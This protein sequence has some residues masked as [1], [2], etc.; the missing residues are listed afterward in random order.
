MN[1]SLILKIHIKNVT[2]VSVKGENFVRENRV[3]IWIRTEKIRK[4]IVNFFI[5]SVFFF[6]FVIIAGKFQNYFN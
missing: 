4:Q 1:H 6:G 2:M 3:V 5:D